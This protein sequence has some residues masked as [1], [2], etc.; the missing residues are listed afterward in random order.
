MNFLVPFQHLHEPQNSPGARFSLLGGLNPE[1]DSISISTI[2]RS[3][4][5]LG[6]HIAIQR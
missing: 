3:K 5:V 2:E 6:S 4:E 1:Q